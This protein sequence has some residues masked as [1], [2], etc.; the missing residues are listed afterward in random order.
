MHHRLST[1]P[2]VCLAGA[3][4][5]SATLLNAQNAADF[6]VLSYGAVADGKTLATNAIQAAVDAC[7]QRGGGRVYVPPGTYLVGTV[8]LRSNVTLY[9]ER[10]ATLLGSTNIADYAR[11]NVIVAD[12]VE[13]VGIAGPGTIDGQGQAFWTRKPALERHIEARLPYM[14]VPHHAY[15]RVARTSGT[16]VRFFNCRNVRV[17]DVLMRNSEAWTLHLFLCD[18]VYVRGVRIR[19]PLHGPNLDGIDID[20]CRNVIVADCD[21]ITSDDAMCLKNSQINN[22]SRMCEN[23]TI[24]NCILVTT[25]NAFKLGNQAW[26]GYRNIVFSNSVILAARPDD[27]LA[28]EALQ[29]V[30]GIDN[31]DRG[32]LGPIAG[33]HIETSGVGLIRGVTVSNIVMDGVRSPIFI[34][35]QN[36]NDE[37]RRSSPPG[38]VSDI[39]IENV[40]AY[41]ANAASTIT[42]IN[43]YPV[44]NVTLNNVRIEVEGGRG[45]EWVDR[46]IPE[47]QDAYP[48][49]HMWNG[50]LPAY[51][52]YVRHAN[53]ITM[54][55]VTVTYQKPDQRPLLVCDDVDT[56]RISGLEG[57]PEHHARML[58]RLDNVRNAVMRDLTIPPHV[59]TWFEIRGNGTRNLH[60]DLAG[61]PATKDPISLGEGVEAGQ[62]RVRGMD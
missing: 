4:L 45:V 59:P 5:M 22:Q 55:D 62:V 39:S 40:V 52:F 42:G 17:E 46:P 48:D 28:R 20:G 56:L 54:R 30:V 41:R 36:L 1:A 29:T 8:R 38:P 57:D 47:M 50:P 12:N 51:G 53:R 21:I 26:E 16:L 6:N 13:N 11:R 44:E 18:D 43:G 7:N 34:R 58:I 15:R 9:L 33:I 2:V 32:F 23:V 37:G 31:H 49:P 3:L 60:L 27:P 25:C 19:N 14:W 61:A 10:G 24:T 35:R